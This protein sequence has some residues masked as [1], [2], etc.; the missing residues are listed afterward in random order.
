MRSLRRMSIRNKLTAFILL[1]SGAA[2]LTA[3]LAC[4]A[5]EIYRARETMAQDLT[6]LAEVVAS[7]AAGPLAFKD[8]EAA[9]D[10]LA[11]LQVRPEIVEARLLNASGGEL[12]RFHLKDAGGDFILPA[13]GQPYRAHGFK[14][15]VS[16][17]VVHAGERLGSLQVTANIRSTLGQLAGNATSAFLLVLV[18]ALIIAYALA[19]RFQRTI[20]EPLLEL[21]GT[22]KRVA[23]RKDYTLRVQKTGTDEIGDLTEAFNHMLAEIQSRDQ[24]LQRESAE[25]LQAQEATRALERKLEQAQRLESLGVLAGG[26]AHDF[27]NILT[28]IL[29][30]ASLAR[31]DVPTGSGLDQLLERMETSSHRAAELCE[32]ML[33]YA[34]KGRVGVRA[35]DL[36]K[37][38]HE[39]LEMLKASV[40]SDAE[41]EVQLDPD[42]PAVRGD[43]TRLRQVLMNLIL[44]AAEALGTGRRRITVTTRSVALTAEAIARLASPGDS[45]PGDFVIVE[46]SDTGVGIAPDKIHRIFEP[47]YTSKFAGRGLGLSAVLG[48]IRGFGGALDLTSELGKGTTFTVFFPARQ[49]EVPDGGPADTTAAVRLQA[50][51]GTVLVVDDEAVVREVATAALVQ[52]GF[53]VLEAADGASA[54]ALLK[55]YNQPLSGVLL[56][57]TMPGMDGAS[58]LRALRELR[59]GLK[60]VL[61]SGFDQQDTLSRHQDLEVVG[62]LPK[63][64]TVK[65]LTSLM[66]N[67]RAT[68]P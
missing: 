49:G 17:P 29:C 51:G 47:F 68:G 34:G 59:P 19:A 28:G 36:N 23:E 8:A 31:L 7:N 54:V 50:S 48:I 6:A 58:T 33:A 20:T 46:I 12:G 45:A 16:Q 10:L 61:M 63:P 5:F 30:S 38:I 35:L 9:Q 41:L 60:A 62:F 55:R 37:L 44:N 32:Q 67:L 11:A 24:A 42:L 21:S 18:A 25:R 64:F 13:T 14:I 22:A 53:E 2:L 4:F 43:A 3:L 65:T 40:P 52:I 39:T 27:N 15:Y 56:D 57:L 26:I 66:A 1:T